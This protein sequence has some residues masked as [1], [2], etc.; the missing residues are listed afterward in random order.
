MRIAEVVGAVTLAHAHPSMKGASL[1]LV[2]PLTAAELA[3]GA[4]GQGDCLAAWDPH[5]AG[6]GDLVALSEGSE[7]AQPF[8]PDQKPVDAYCAAILD[9]VHLGAA[10]AQ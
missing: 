8:R 1:R 3:S 7:A 9:N 6:V 10:G 5:G 4:P 2:V